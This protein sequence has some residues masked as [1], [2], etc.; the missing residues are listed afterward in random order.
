M[1]NYREHLLLESST[2]K[3]ALKKLDILAKDAILFVVDKDDKLIGSLTDGDIRRG[4]LNEVSIEENVTVVLQPN[5]RFVRKG[6]TE[7]RKVIEYRDGNYRIIPVLDKNDK[8]VN[9]INFRFFKSYL[10]I[11][12]VIMAGGRGERLRPLTDSTPKPLLKIGEKPIIEHNIDRLIS[13]GIDDFWLSVRYL[14]EQLQGYF[15]DGEQKN[16]KVEYVWETEPLGTIG[17]V[18][19]INNFEHDYILVTNSDILTNLDYEDFFLTFLESG[20]DLSVLTIPYDVKVP[21]AVL[22]TSNNHVLSF[23]EKPTYTY[24]SNGGIYLIKRELLELIPEGNFF[25]ATDFMETLINKNYKVHSYPL[26][27]YW[28]DIGKHQDYKKAQEDIKHI[29]F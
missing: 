27:G 2:I 3:D 6:E 12:A 21:Y 1:I 7:I 4:L 5:P 16:I 19:K 23:K 14:G 9:I 13:F 26:R 11:D 10:P 22:E 29:K 8:V 18:S 24:Y 20:A 15:K 28:L 17:A 25:D